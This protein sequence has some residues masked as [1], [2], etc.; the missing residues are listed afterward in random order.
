LRV[1]TVA[2]DITTLW[3]STKLRAVRHRLGFLVQGGQRPARSHGKSF[4]GN[5]LRPFR[6]HH[7]QAAI[8]SQRRIDSRSEGHG[9]FVL[10][11]FQSS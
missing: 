6:R 9:A 10:V 11:I 2:D 5:D 4:E 8:G 1:G 7:E 3:L